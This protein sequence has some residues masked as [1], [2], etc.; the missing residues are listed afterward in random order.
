MHERRTAA[1]ASRHGTGAALR[2]VTLLAGVALVSGCS[3]IGPDAPEQATPDTP[4]SDRATGV[5]VD[6]D[7]GEYGSACTQEGAHVV[8]SSVEYSVDEVPRADGEVLKVALRYTAPDGP[9]VGLSTS[10]LG[11]TETPE[12]WEGEVG[13][14]LEYEGWDLTVTSI[15]ANEVRFD[16]VVVT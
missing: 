14:T 13:D 1:H 6:G 9:R 11:G 15:C 8:D 16:V 4:P 10:L 2:L 3:L 5:H 12:P 7:D